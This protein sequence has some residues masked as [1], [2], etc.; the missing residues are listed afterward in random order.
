M[1]VL[2]DAEGDA[3]YIPLISKRIRVERSEWV[4]ARRIVD[5]DA[6]GKP[7]GIEVLAASRGKRLADLRDRFDLGLGD[8]EVNAIERHL[9]QPMQYAPPF[10]GA[11]A[12]AE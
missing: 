4:D 8:D 9:F 1:R 3:L 11:R 5:L 12:P 6:D 7:L 10:E 2:Y